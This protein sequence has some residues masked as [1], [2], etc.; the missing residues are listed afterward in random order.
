MSKKE[1]DNKEWVK[2]KKLIS[3][4]PHEFAFSNDLEIIIDEEQVEAFEEMSGK[5]IGVCYE[6]SYRMMVVD[7][8]FDGKKY[9]AY[10]RLLQTVEKGSV[11]MIPIYR[12]N[13][14]L[15]NQYRHALRDNQYAFP[16]GF[17]E[18]GFTA[19]ENCKKELMEELGCNTNSVDF[20]GTLVVDS[21]LNGDKVSVF[22]CEVDGFTEKQ[23]YEGIQNVLEVSKSKMKELI[24]EN[25]I[26]DGFSLSAYAMFMSKAGK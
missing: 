17:A 13:F 24:A 20:L 5:T 19:E 8:V 18:N 21:G 14:L 2:Y 22:A 11:V 16:R 4:R 9:F 6:S 26:T 12:D 10:E 25:L 3:E 7:L 23:G 1:K 15:L